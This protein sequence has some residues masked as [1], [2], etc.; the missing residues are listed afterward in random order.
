MNK[1]FPSNSEIV[2]NLFLDA[3]NFSKN[4]LVSR[5][6]LS[7]YSLVSIILWFSNPHFKH[8]F[9]GLSVNKQDSIYEWPHKKCTLGNVNGLSQLAHLVAEN[10]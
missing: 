5:L 3:P 6:D 7:D 8:S 10:T 2:S 4:P 1:P 9:S